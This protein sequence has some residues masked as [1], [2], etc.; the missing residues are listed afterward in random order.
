MVMGHT[1]N[2]IFLIAEVHGVHVLILLGSL[3]GMKDKEYDIKFTLAENFVYSFFN[4]EF[5]SV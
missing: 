1:I 3:D 5:Q 2:S 4:L